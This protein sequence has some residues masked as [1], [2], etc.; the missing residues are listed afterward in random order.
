MN[1]RRLATVDGNQYLSSTATRTLLRHGQRQALKRLA[2]ADMID[3]EDASALVGE[4]AKTIKRWIARRWC[5]GL[6]VD[7][8]VLRLPRWQF[9]GDLLLWVEPIFEALDTRSGWTVLSFLEAP[10]GALEGRTPRQ[11]LEQGDVAQVLDLA[12]FIT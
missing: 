8:H 7:G 5:I 6:T 1:A 3:L 2:R 10:N 9:D 11:A 4:S 12:S